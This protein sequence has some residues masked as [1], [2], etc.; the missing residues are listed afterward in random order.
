MGGQTLLE[1]L[2]AL[3][4]GKEMPHAV[5]PTVG[6]NVSKC[7]LNG[8]HCQFW[9]MGGGG[10]LPKLWAKYYG[11]AHAVFFVIDSTAMEEEERLGRL[12]CILGKLIIR[13][14]GAEDNPNM[15]VLLAFI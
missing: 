11:E 9:D 2:K 15:L 4:Q 10:D 13:V 5:T 3:L 8:I 14:T 12:K 6:L 7:D 1:Q